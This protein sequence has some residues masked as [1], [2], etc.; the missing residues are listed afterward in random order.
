MDIANALQG[1]CLACSGVYKK[2]FLM[3][4]SFLLVQLSDFEK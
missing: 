2:C 1:D 4:C 3:K